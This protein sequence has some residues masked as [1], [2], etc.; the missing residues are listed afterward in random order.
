ML[1]CDPHRF[2]FVHIPKCA[3][4]TVRA[5]IRRFDSCDGF[6][7][8]PKEH[9]GLGRVDFAHIP[10]RMLARAFPEV[11][12]KLRDY[13]S[14]AVIRDPLDRFGSSLRQTLHFY[15]HVYPTEMSRTELHDAV[16]RMIDRLEGA[17]DWARHD[18]A[19]FQRQVDFV[20]LDGERIVDRLFPMTRVGQMLEDIGH[21][22]G[23][24][25]EG[26][27]KRNRDLS[28]RSRALVRPAYAINAFLWRHAPAGLHASLKRFALPLIT[29][30]DS[31]T[32]RLG[33]TDL[34]EVHDFVNRYYSE[35]A[36]LHASLVAWSA[37]PTASPR[38]QPRAD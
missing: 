32:K 27:E 21:L 14:F 10:L 35:D 3:G 18:L 28:F 4:T 12:Q 20:D 5:R 22:A 36:A 25:L 2:A 7:E 38:E 30:R 34:A 8:R 15:E 23:V 11:L 6:F 37:Q 13:N 16:R 9:P 31:A 29:H 26:E 24:P 1:I 17:P 33:I 19:F